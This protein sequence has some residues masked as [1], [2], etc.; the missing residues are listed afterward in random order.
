VRNA[1]FHIIKSAQF[2]GANPFMVAMLAESDVTA[3]QG[4]NS[5]LNA[6]YDYSNYVTS[7]SALTFRSP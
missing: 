1:A 3:L 2:S 7:P 6:A 4:L 5:D